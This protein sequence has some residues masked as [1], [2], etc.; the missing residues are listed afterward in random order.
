MQSRLQLVCGPAPWLRAAIAAAVFTAFLSILSVPTPPEWRFAALVLLAITAFVEWRRV[1]RRY[2]SIVLS[3]DG[4]LLY[5]GS[6]GESRG[7][8]LPGGW[9]S[10]WLCV[11]PWRPVEGGHVRNALVCASLNSEADF[12]RLRVRIRLGAAGAEEALP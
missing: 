9:I 1:S 4:S 5:R 11:L 7:H 2:T 6:H 8:E 3:S 10:P 12:R